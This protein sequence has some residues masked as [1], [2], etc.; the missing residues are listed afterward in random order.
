MNIKEI[1]IYAEV[2]EQGLDFRDYVKRAGYAGV[3]RNVYVKKTRDEFSPQDSVIDRIRKVKDADVLISALSGD[4][5]HPLLMV[6][7]S[8]A[9]PTDDH[10]MQRSDVYYWSAVFKVPTMKISPS[11]KGMSQDFG[12][13]SR[14]TDEQEQRLAFERGALFFPIKW[15]TPPGSD[16]LPTKENALSCIPS[17]DAVQETIA[18]IID[19]FRA[20]N[21]ACDFY[22]RLKRQY[23]AKY[24]EPL[25]RT[26]VSSIKANVVNSSRFH[27]YGD[28][29]AVKINRFGHAMDPDRG[30]LYYANMLVGAENTITVV[31]VNRPDDPAARGGYSALFDALARKKELLGYVSDIICHSANIFTDE[32]ALHVFACGLNID[33]AVRFEKVSEH[34]YRIKDDVL[35]RFLFAHVGMAAKSI[36]FLST[37]LRLIDKNRDTICT[38]RW[39]KEPILK[40][41]DS[42]NTNNRAP[43]PIKPLTMAEAKEDIVTFASVELYKKMGCK[44]LAVSYPGAQGDRCILTGAGRKVLRIYVD[45]IAY[46]EDANGITVFLEE[47][48]DKF[49]RSQDDVIK[50]CRIASGQEERDGL[51][52]LFR[53]TIGRDSIRNLFISVAAK[54]DASPPK[55]SVN[56]T[57]MF[58]LSFDSQHTYIDYTVNVADRAAAAEFSPLMNGGKLAG[59]LEYDKLYVIQEKAVVF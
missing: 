48:K 7:Y 23:A 46:K 39:N 53:K 17:S 41:L 6:E 18:S 1:R 45:I 56:Y 22:D 40:Y 19:T 29:L 59:R 52:A 10:K 5:E 13:G 36:F 9:V 49:S 27:W 26:S 28:K 33:K 25:T 14:I 42:V 58:G 15:D 43:I 2:L 51:K 24:R 30:V 20:C 4:K 11:K 55:F 8:T 37:E 44:L 16:V 57:F 3:I 50:L 21:G 54:K 34:N 35:E 38:V 12:G 32:N 31:Q 47:C